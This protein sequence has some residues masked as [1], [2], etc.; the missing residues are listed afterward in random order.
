M[1]DIGTKYKIG[2]KKFGFINWIG[3]WTLY[4]KEVLELNKT[5][6]CT[7]FY[8]SKIKYI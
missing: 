5:I 6:K 8:S 4:K 1:V 7:L 3:T 2:V